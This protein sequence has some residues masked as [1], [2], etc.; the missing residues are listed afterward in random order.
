MIYTH[1]AREGVAG[2]TSPLDVLGDLTAQQI[3]DAVERDRTTK[4]RWDGDCR[5][6]DL[7]ERIERVFNQ[8]E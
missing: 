3:G 1:V 4:R 5:G 8:R 6:C 2:L 7:F